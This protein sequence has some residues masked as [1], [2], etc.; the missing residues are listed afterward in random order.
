[1]SPGVVDEEDIVTTKVKKGQIVRT[2]VK[3]ESSEITARLNSLQY[4]TQQIW[5]FQ[6]GQLAVCLLG[7]VVAL[8]VAI[9][10]A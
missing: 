5:Y 10:Y 4:K 8:M 2:Q 1:M 3:L 7:L 6:L 9:K